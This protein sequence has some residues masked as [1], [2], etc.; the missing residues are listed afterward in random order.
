M[1]FQSFRWHAPCHSIR[2]G[3]VIP[4]L[5]SAPRAFLERHALG[6]ELWQWSALVLL[7]VCSAA[8]GTLLSRLARTVL[9]HFARR[10][11]FEWD[12]AL[13][14]R[15]RGP[16]GLA[17]AVA[18]ALFALPVIELGPRTQRSL[19]VVLRLGWF[20]AVFW[21]LVRGTDIL[22]NAISRTE[23]GRRNR[24][25]R[26]LIKVAARG[27]K[28]L[29]VVVA[30]VSVLSELD[31]PIT[32][33]IAGL[34][35]GGLAFALGAQKTLENLFGAVSLA[36]DQPLREGDLVRIDEEIGWVETIGLRST[37]IRSLD[38]TLITIPNGKL[39]EMRIES[40][41]ARDRMRLSCRMG[42]VSR[43]SVA[44]LRK[45]RDDFVAILRAHEKIWPDLVNVHFVEIG[46]SSFDI[47]VMAWFQTPSWIEFLE[48]RHDILLSFVE[49]VEA[50]GS[51]FAYPT[52]TLH[53]K[54][55]S[56][57]RSE[58]EQREPAPSHH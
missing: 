41:A 20:A 35:L 6:L 33:M 54:S 4:E 2:V 47:E 27:L 23:W 24:A 46:E 48:I 44:Q 3:T 50:A 58:D 12:N 22:V 56:L 55:Y 21:A 15:S 13:V 25:T 40:L 52:Q 34:G 16:L 10:T 5:V 42:L 31:Y 19:V 18:I 1:A 53:L 17:I 57:G 49:A 39:A 37:R 45:I 36:V 9:G 7:I 51:A 26:S 30:V 29:L 32:S 43:T 14:R 38:R 11:P 8:L 28:V